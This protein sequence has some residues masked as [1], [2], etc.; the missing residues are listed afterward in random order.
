MRLWRTQNMQESWR[1]NLPQQRLVITVAS[2]IPNLR[3]FFATNDL[4][5]KLI[6]HKNKHT[7]QMFYL[8]KALQ[9]RQVAT[10]TVEFI[11]EERGG[12]KPQNDSF[13][14]IFTEETWTRLIQPAEDGT[15]AILTALPNTTARRLR[16]NEAK[17]IMT[18]DGTR[19]ILPN[20]TF[21]AIEETEVEDNE[22]ESRIV[23]LL[24]SGHPIF[25]PHR[26]T[27]DTEIHA[28]TPLK[29]ILDPKWAGLRIH[30]LDLQYPEK[31]LMYLYN[32]QERR[33]AQRLNIQKN[34]IIWTD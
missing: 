24:T 31:I 25:M 22:D 11:F 23:N 14:A 30:D 12:T 29:D 19:K 10:E 13:V 16:S 4:K 1:E 33:Q 3:A 5:Q 26:T 20:L 2:G 6:T 34:V 27:G 15:P 17:E 21:K 32:L 7:A 28:A 8:R 18:L 9:Q